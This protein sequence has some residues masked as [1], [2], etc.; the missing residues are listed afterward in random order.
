MQFSKI[1]SLICGAA[2]ILEFAERLV[3]FRRTCNMQQKFSWAVFLFS[4]TKIANSSYSKKMTAVGLG[5]QGTQAVCSVL[6]SL[7]CQAFIQFIPIIFR[8]PKLVKD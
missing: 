6:E 3:I 4:Q 8:Y 5:Q 1:C 7:P 2:N